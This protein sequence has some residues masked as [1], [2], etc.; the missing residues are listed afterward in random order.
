[1]RL[2]FIILRKYLYYLK[3][4][5]MIV[6]YI[7]IKLTRGRVTRCFAVS[8]I[9]DEI[10]RSNF[11]KN[12]RLILIKACYLEIFTGNL[13]NFYFN[14]VKTQILCKYIFFATYIHIKRAARCVGAQAWDC[15]RNSLC[16]RFPLEEM[17]IYY[18]YFFALVTSRQ[19]TA[20]SSA[21]QHAMTP[22]FGGKLR[23]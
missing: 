7:L 5:F 1:M 9:Y 3:F 20:L 6:V 11:R 2:F 18:F 13:L 16:G 12:F 8:A 21:T 10:L 14:K 15:K 19:S 22:E 17:N 23:T 4:I